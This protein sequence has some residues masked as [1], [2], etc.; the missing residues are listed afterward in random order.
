MKKMLSTIG[1]AISILLIVFG[2]MTTS[3]SFGDA[4]YYGNS[5]PYDS[6]FASFNGDY[7][8]YSVNNGAEA[9]SAARAVASNVRE[10]SQL[11]QSALGLFMICFGALSFCGFGIVF[12]GCPKAQADIAAPCCDATAPAEEPAAEAA[13]QEAPIEIAN[14]AE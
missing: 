3:G 4:T 6:G 1:M 5:S 13:E 9:A 10:V 8:T 7:Y 11:L 2:I 14:T 12:S